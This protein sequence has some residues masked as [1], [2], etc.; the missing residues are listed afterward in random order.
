MTAD[1]AKI[2]PVAVVWLGMLWV[3]PAAALAGLAVGGALALITRTLAV[4]VCI[5]ALCY[6]FGVWLIDHP[7]LARMAMA[8]VLAGGLAWYYREGLRVEP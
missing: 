6:P 2:A 1:L 5:A 8:F 7:G 4:S 3:S